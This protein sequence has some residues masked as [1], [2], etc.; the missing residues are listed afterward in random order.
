MNKKVQGEGFQLT[1]YQQVGDL[2]RFEDFTGYIQE[3]TRCLHGAGKNL[4][5]KKY[6]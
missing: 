4:G 6:V 3:F 1:K 2:T 5:Y